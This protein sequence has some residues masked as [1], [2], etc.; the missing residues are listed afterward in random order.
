M[1]QIRQKTN[2]GIPFFP[3]LTSPRYYLHAEFR[4][5][6]NISILNHIFG[7]TYNVSRYLKIK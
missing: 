5:Y 2:K 4:L 3:L 7:V 6:G 1:V